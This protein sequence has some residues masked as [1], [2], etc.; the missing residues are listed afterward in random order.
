[1]K[2]QSISVF[3]DVVKF[4]DFRWKMLMSV[5]LKECVTWFIYIFWSSFGNKSPPHPWA[6]PKKLILNRV[7]IDFYVALVYG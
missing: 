4:A 1:M 6:V 2:I 7:K 3:L 5:E